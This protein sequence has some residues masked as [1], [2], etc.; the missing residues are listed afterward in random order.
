M[1]G[2][3]LKQYHTYDECCLTSNIKPLCQ[4]KNFPNFG[5]KYHLPRLQ[6]PV[7]GE[8]GVDTQFYVKSPLLK[9]VLCINSNLK[10]SHC[11]QGN[12]RKNDSV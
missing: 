7:C 8:G 10:K 4:F 9:K 3:C 2:T 1:S 11:L 5:L 6:S 12:F